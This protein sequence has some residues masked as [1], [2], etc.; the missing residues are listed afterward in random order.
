MI[1]SPGEL[2]ML[3]LM[4]R[5]S[6]SRRINPSNT[7][8]YEFEGQWHDMELIEEVIKV[9]GGEDVVLEVRATRHGPIITDIQDDVNDVLALQWT[10][11]EPSRI[12]QSIVLLIR[13][14]Y[15]EFHDALRYWD[16]PSQNII[17]ADVE[18]NIAYQ[19]QALFRYARMATEKFRCP[20]G[21]ASTSGKAGYLTKSYRPSSIP[22]KA[23]LSPPIMPLWMRNIRTS[24]PATGLMAIG[25]SEL[26]T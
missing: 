4:Y 12:L 8:Q 26:S 22:K 19:M 23:I 25:A 20:V 15:E 6:S 10:Q 9:N 2:P 7:N 5:I 11:Q 3:A 24:L 17:Y 1:R 16:V 18:G 14:K 21:Q 13:L